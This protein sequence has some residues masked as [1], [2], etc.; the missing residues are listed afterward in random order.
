MSSEGDVQRLPGA[1]QDPKSYTDDSKLV[2][3]C[4]PQDGEVLLDEKAWPSS[5]SSPKDTVMQAPAS[6]P[7]QRASNDDRRKPDRSLYKYYL[8]SVTVPVIVIFI[9]GLA[10]TSLLERMPGECYLAM[11]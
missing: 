10:L 7:L 6:R 4:A 11:D 9:S 5:D 8:S 1:T 3:A 2:S